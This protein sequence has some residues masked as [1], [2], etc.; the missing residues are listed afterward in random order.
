MSAAEPET[1]VLLHG[2][3]GTHR[4]WDGVVGVLDPQRY[5]PLALD[6]RGHG[7]AG[8]RRPID[9]EGC[10]ADVLDSAQ[11]CFC[12]C[13]YSMGGRLALHVAL[14]APQRVTRMVLIGANPG[15]EDPAL[16]AERRGADARLAE[17][18]ESEDDIEAFAEAWRGQSLFAGDPAGVVGAAR[19]DYRRNR[20]SALAAALRGMGTGAMSPLW[21][22]LDQL[23]M[24][25]LVLAGERDARYR[26]IGERIVRTVPRGRILVLPGGHAVQL[27]SPAEV[28]SAI[29]A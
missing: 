15:I 7:S 29:G 18:I 24:P 27:E 2:F 16:R 1:L 25:V 3:A 4:A 23:N 8:D 12:L 13:G 14:A 10:V 11:G 5:R 20:P 9:F 17:R 21:G 6:L 26:E 19:E 22:R 28:A